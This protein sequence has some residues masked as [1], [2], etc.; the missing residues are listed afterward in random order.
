[1]VSF[2][3]FFFFFFEDYILAMVIYLSLHN[4]SFAFLRYFVMQMARQ[5]YD[6]HSPCLQ[7][8]GGTLSI[9]V[10]AQKI[11]NRGKEGTPH[12][13]TLKAKP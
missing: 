3:G 1:L 2:R 4:S 13:H 12:T 7:R 10:E 9:R 5:Q 11:I 6:T 8:R